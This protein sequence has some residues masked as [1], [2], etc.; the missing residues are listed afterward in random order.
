M[1]HRILSPARLE[2][3]A[4]WTTIFDREGPLLMEIGFG[5]GRYLTHLAAQYP[6][7][8]IV[9]VEIS[10][11]SLRRVAGWQERGK[12]P[13]VRL[14]H[15]TA[16]L[17]LQLLCAPQSL[18]GLYINFPDPWPK[19]AHHHRRLINDRFLALAASRLLPGTTLH[20]ATDHAAYAEQITDCLQ[21]TVYFHSRTETPFVIAEQ[22]QIGTKYELKGLAE[23]RPGHYYDWRRNET[24]APD[25][26]PIFPEEPVPHLILQTPDN[27]DAIAAQFA[28]WQW[29]QGETHIRFLD[30]YRS[31]R[32]NF[33]LVEAFVIEGPLEQRVGLSVR[34][35]P[36]SE[37]I[38]NVHEIGF[39]RPTP[40]V[41]H[42]VARL[43]D[44]LLSLHPNA[45]LITQNL[46]D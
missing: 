17:I 18:S 3:P 9:G 24:P 30:I 27:L 5:N 11:P 28:P 21:R 36:S 13:H 7:A 10:L 2:W 26:F 35:R 23:G 6:D 39:P 1:F 37:L 22:A 29:S 44:W 32:D 34:A 43:G 25:D 38:L 16:E 15:G 20:I 8:N 19:D 46:A 45:Q 42:A 14:L 41:H 33:L 4:P 31:T 40:G 12:L